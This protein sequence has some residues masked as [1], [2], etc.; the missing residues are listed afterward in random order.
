MKSELQ[1]KAVL[2]LYIIRLGGRT[3]RGRTRLQKLIFLTQEQVKEL[4]GFKFRPAQQG[5]L[6]Y[7]VYQ[8]MNSLQALGLVEESEDRTFAGHKVICYRLSN[9]GR[10]F[11]E[12]A[13]EKE[14]VPQSIYA[15]AKRVFKEYGDLPY[16]S[17]I[18]KV[19][20]EYPEYVK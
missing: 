15:A 7:E 14:L 6:S 18:D 4:K 11:L 17:L 3:F 5:P 1:A 2:V 8:L 13:A 19:H 10:S 12:F 20:S 9:Q 16:M